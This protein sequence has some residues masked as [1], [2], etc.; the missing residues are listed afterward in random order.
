MVTKSK[1]FCLHPF[2]HLEIANDGSIAPCC[3]FDRYY[4]MDNGTN[5]TIS[6]SFDSIVN[7]QYSLELKKSLLDGEQHPGCHRC[8]RDEES[9]FNSQRE[10]YNRQYAE[11]S[12]QFTDHTQFKLLSFDLKL[13]NTCNQMCVICHPGNSSMIMSEY[14]VRFGSSYVPATGLDWYRH[15]ENIEKIESQLDSILHID[16]FGGEPWLIKQQWDI[17]QKIISLGRSHNVTLNYATNGSIFQEDF[18][19]T[20]SKFKKVSILF[21]ADG[22]E[23]TFEYNRYPGKWSVFKNNLNQSLT[24]MNP[25]LSLRIAY[26]V[27]IYSIFN[28]IESLKYYKSISTDT[29]KLDV[30]FNIVNDDCFNIKN[31]PDNIK[32]TLIENLTQHLGQ[33][34]PLAEEHGLYSLIQELRRPRY[35]PAWEEFTLITQLRDEHRKQSV[36]NIIPEISSTISY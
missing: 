20:F 34:W 23:E 5:A 7:S 27:S 24:Y 28:V 17:L 16:F 32:Q 21:S 14:K 35:Q 22:I 11:Y 10:R 9:G 30:W 1:T 6:N 25:K 4:K 36:S 31:L 8:W 15:S 29:R 26:T 12:D 19:D 33:D 18:F 13:G 2:T 3:N